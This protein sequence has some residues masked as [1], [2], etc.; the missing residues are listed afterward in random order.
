MSPEPTLNSMLERAASVAGQGLRFCGSGEGDRLFEWSEIHARADRVAAAL[1]E[2]GIHRGDRVALVFATGVEFFDAFFGVLLAAAV[3]VPLYPPVR[4]GRLD[5]YHARTAEMMRAA[6]VRL[7]LTES[8]VHRILGRTLRGA[9]PELGCRLLGELQAVATRRLEVGANELAL[10]QFSSG[11]T[12]QPKP[13]AL[14][15]RALVAQIRAL[16]S[17]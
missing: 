6:G 14:S 10:V 17:F 8:R 11:T 15:H 12:V 13:V 2:I 5:E 9:R 16:N 4:L 7:V 3:P 1:P